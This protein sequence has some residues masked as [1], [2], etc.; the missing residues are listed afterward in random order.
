MFDIGWTEMMVVA[1]VAI[2]FVGPKE[3]P[4]MLR[5]IGR[6]IKKIRAMAGDFQ[7]QFNDALKDSELDGVK[8]TI[9]DVRNLDPTKAIKD[10]LNPLKSELEDVKKSVEDAHDFD[11]KNFSDD[12]DKSKL[13][14]DS[15]LEKQRKIDAEFA[16]V[17]PSS[18][19]NA[20]PGFGGP[21]A[22]PLPD[23]KPAIKVPA[24]AKST[25]KVAPKKPAPKKATPKKSTAAKP[26]AKASDAKK[27]PA[28]RKPSKKAEA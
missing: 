4:G 23:P 12:Y 9:N 26:K 22:D 16:K 15:A 21:A 27:A 1:I 11:P 28:K 2:L 25:A 13:D 5:T 7:E 10:K 18:G 6:S 3:L 24:K 14:S 20:V 17:A 8:D 19:A